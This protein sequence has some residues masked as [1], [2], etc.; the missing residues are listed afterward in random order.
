M[1]GVAIRGDTHDDPNDLVSIRS[2]AKGSGGGQDVP[3]LAQGGVEPI[4]ATTA[5][6]SW[7]TRRLS[8]SAEP[9]VTRVRSNAPGG[10]PRFQAESDTSGTF[11]VS[12]GNRTHPWRGAMSGGR[13][14]ASLRRGHCRPSQPGDDEAASVVLPDVW[15]F[16][17]SIAPLR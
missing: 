5:G 4:G 8:G 9:Y 11:V 17:G 2:A 3:S 1:A 16:A 14:D 13:T 12:E 10:C 6:L 15:L 7:R